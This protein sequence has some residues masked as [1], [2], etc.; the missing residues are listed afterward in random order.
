MHRCGRGMNKD[1]FQAASGRA[2]SLR[3][4]RGIVL[5]GDGRAKTIRGFLIPAHATR[6][7][8]KAPTGAGHANPGAFR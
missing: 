4:A 6:P 5:P 7:N 2:A 3:G 1:I 8:S